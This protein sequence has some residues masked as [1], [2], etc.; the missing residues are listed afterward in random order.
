MK[1]KYIG[2]GEDGDHAETTIYGITFT[3]GEAVDVPEGVNAALGV[4]IA[5]RLAESPYF[6]V[7]TAGKRAASG[8]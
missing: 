3:K 7:V 6:E 8:E 4:D 2:S 1:L 5:K